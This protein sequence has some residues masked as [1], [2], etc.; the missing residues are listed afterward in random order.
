MLDILES[1][2]KAM[3]Y[4]AIEVV[5]DVFIAECDE[6][7]YTTR[8]EENK[9]Y[10]A[11]TNFTIFSDEVTNTLVS[12]FDIFTGKWH[13]SDNV[14][15]AFYT[16]AGIGKERKEQL[17][18]GTCLDLPNECILKTLSSEE[19]CPDNV[20]SIVWHV[21]L[22]EYR[23]QYAART[24]KGNLESLENCQIGKFKEFLSH[25]S[26]HFG[27]E[28]EV[29]LRHQVLEAIRNSKLHNF[30]VANKEE[31]ILALLLEKLDSTQN[32]KNFADRFTHSSDVELIFIQAQSE[33]THDVLDPVWQSMKELEADITD[34]RNLAEKIKAVCPTYDDRKMKRLARLACIAK[35]EQVSSDKSFLS[36]KYR[37]YEACDEYLCQL[38]VTEELPEHVFET[39]L[40]GL[41]SLAV[42]NID[43]LKADYKYSISN[44]QTIIAII[45]DLIDSC[46]VSFDTQNAE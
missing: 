21:L 32:L 44:K 41:K 1:R 16:T 36:L 23:K 6:D 4:A 17:A 28:D 2:P 22:E 20:A 34:K 43:T 35:I 18:D 26:W 10:A 13:F 19:S 25:I 45:M 3:F 12:F 46:F 24:G 27:Q 8:F 31:I 33:Q 37:V 11:G 15:L 9:N 42:A 38:A 14:H 39:M 7:E 5:E 40:T 29:S 30:R